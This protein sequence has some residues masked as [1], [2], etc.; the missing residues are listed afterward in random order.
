MKFFHRSDVSLWTFI[1]HNQWYLIIRCYCFGS[2]K[3]QSNKH[4]NF[5]LLSFLSLI[6]GNVIALQIVYLHSLLTDHKFSFF[7]LQNYHLLM[8][9]VNKQF[10]IAIVSSNILTS[11]I[12]EAS[13][14]F[15][16]KISYCRLASN[17]L[18]KKMSKSHLGSVL[19][20]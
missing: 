5:E 11:T 16:F 9:S 14:V 10:G 12:K 7:L 4:T 1:C 2:L 15:I 17:C 20:L 3:S 8:R 6:V 19:Q 13:P 18:K